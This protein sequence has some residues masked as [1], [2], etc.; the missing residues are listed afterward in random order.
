M[1]I[2]FVV[3]SATLMLVDLFVA[4]MNMT[5]SVAIMQLDISATL[6]QVKVSA[7][8]MWVTILLKFCRWESV[9]IM[10]SCRWYF[11]QCIMYMTI[12]IVIMHVAVSVLAMYVTASSS[13]FIFLSL[14]S[15]FHK[16]DQKTFN[17]IIPSLHFTTL[18]NI[19]PKSR[20]FVGRIYIQIS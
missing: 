1:A 17:G 9:A 20:Y 14:T 18:V 12:S 4:V 7:A 8:N 5:V 6:L 19:L 2:M 13:N 11:L 15:I 3:F 10:Q 16:F